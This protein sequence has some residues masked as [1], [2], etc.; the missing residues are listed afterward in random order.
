M[1]CQIEEE[2]ACSMLADSIPDLTSLFDWRANFMAP[3]SLTTNT[4]H[5]KAC[6]MESTPYGRLLSS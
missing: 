4:N 1:S 3:E 5:S 6:R 2:G